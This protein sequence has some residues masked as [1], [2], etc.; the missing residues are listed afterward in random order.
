M[1]RSNRFLFRFAGILSLQFLIMIT[2]I[3][4][5][6]FTWGASREEVHMSMPGDDLAPFISSTRSISIHAPASDVWNWLVRLGADRGGFYSYWFIERPLG[7]QYRTQDRIEPEFK[8]MEVG[9]I[10]SASLNPSESV[11]QYSFPVLAA[12]REKYFVLKNWGCFLLQEEGADHTRLIVRTHGSEI[13]GPLDYLE[14]SFMMPMH[15]LM[16]RRMLMGI[17]ARAEAG[18]GMAFSSTDDILWFTGI[19][20]SMATIVGLLAIGRGRTMTLLTVLYSIA[21]LWILFVIDPIPVYSL[22]F[23]TLPAISICWIFRTRPH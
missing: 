13:S 23:L 9:R 2:M 3:R 22:S 21:W 10:I 11:I 18:R 12:E 4:P 8:E 14:Y 7:Y 1:N 5:L 6:I 17:K 15:Y 16:E 20:L 19:L